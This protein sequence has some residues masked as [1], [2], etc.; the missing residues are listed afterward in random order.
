VGVKPASGKFNRLIIV[1]NQPIKIIGHKVKILVFC[2]FKM[3]TGNKDEFLEK[4]TVFCGVL[5][6]KCLSLCPQNNCV[7]LY[8]VDY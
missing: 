4:E 5:P 6:L 1:D 2:F 7:N 3:L 8:D